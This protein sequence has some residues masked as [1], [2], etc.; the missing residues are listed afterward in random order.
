MVISCVGFGCQNRQGS[1]GNKLIKNL[2]P[3][4]FHRF[5][6][7]KNGLYDRWLKSVKR[8]KWTPTKY[9]YLCSEHFLINDYKV[10]PWGDRP[11]LKK[12]TIPSVFC[13]FPRHLQEKTSKKRKTNNSCATELQPFNEIVKL[14]EFKQD[15]ILQKKKE[16]R[17]PP[18]ESTKN[19]AKN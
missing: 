8:W 11:R 2:I 19:G 16:K 14:D 15:A 12:G 3:I 1:H 17:S 18:G 7:N 5:P 4:S 6:N 13:Q 9:S 10:P